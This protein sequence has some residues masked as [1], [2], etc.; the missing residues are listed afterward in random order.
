MKYH[1]LNYYFRKRYTEDKKHKKY[2]G[3]ARIKKTRATQ[4]E[5]KEMKEETRQE[6]RR[7]FSGRLSI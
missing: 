6:L 3:S 7:L 5:Q 2:S 4:K 1:T